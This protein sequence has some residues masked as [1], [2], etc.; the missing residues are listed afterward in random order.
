MHHAAG[1]PRPE[2]HSGH[3]VDAVMNDCW[4]RGRGGEPLL[5]DRDMEA[6][7]LCPLCAFRNNMHLQSGLPGW[8]SSLKPGFKL[9]L[10]NLSQLMAL[11][12]Y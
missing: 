3:V 9:S 7:C 2:V 6:E 12:Q 5:Q 8:R 4:A 11:L 1:I 10:L